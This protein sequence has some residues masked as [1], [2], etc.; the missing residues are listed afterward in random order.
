ML[1]LQVFNKVKR[2]HY[3]FEKNE[4]AS[5]HSSQTVLDGQL[6]TLSRRT[7]GEYNFLR[8]AIL[9]R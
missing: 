6:R 7:D 3:N 2:E 1:Y 5:L 4:F 9:S 8:I